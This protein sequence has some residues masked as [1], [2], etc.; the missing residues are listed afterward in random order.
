M[1]S[2]ISIL[3]LTFFSFSNLQAQQKQLVNKLAEN[4]CTCLSDM[5]LEGLSEQEFQ[6][7]FQN[8]IMKYV[9][10]NIEEIQS[11]FSSLD[12]SDM[13]MAMTNLGKEVFSTLLKKCPETIS[14]ASGMSVEELK[15]LME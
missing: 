7:K 10:S 8:C 11:A 12:E 9:M 4:S 3:A 1:K 6:A 5:N 14:K 15:K 13:M 2:I